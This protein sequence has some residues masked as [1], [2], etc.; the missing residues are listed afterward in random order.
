MGSRPSLSADNVGAAVKRYAVVGLGS[1]SRLYTEALL[2]TYRD[3]G[4]LVAFCDPNQTRMDYFNRD[5]S[6]RFG[7]VPI[8]TYKPDAFDRMLAE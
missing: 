7:T 6:R 1:R 3:H 5:Y 4:A 8:P 2:T